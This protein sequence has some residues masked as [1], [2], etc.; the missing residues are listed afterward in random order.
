MKIV[1]SRVRTCF[2]E[3][4]VAYKN[5]TPRTIKYKSYLILLDEKQPFVEDEEVKI[6]SESDFELIRKMCRD[7]K[8]DK[9]NLLKQMDDLHET[10]KEKNNYVALL[11]DKIREDEQKI[12][13]KTGLMS[14]LFKGHSL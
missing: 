6:L 8:R 12:E 10:L 13:M 7:L 4:L 1:D 3:N 9:D 11:E 14:R 5:K 2:E